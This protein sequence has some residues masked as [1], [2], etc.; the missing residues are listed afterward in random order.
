ME[1]PMDSR[2][3]AVVG[4]QAATVAGIVAYRALAGDQPFLWFSIVLFG[5]A[6]IL[7]ESLSERREGGGFTTY[8]IVA[9]MGGLVATNGLSI[10]LAALFGAV[11][12]RGQNRRDPW[13][14]IFNGLQYAVSIGLASLVYSGLG[15]LSRSLTLGQA[16]RSIPE[17]LL[18]ALVFYVVNSLQVALAQGFEKSLPLRSFYTPA[19]LLLAV[20]QLLY[21]LVGMVAGIIYAQNAF[22]V[23]ERLVAG[24]AGEVLERIVTGSSGEAIRGFAGLAAFFTLLAVAWYFSGK[25][26]A[27]RRG[28]DQALMTLAGYLERREPY[29]PGHSERVAALA[30]MTAK[31]LKVGSYDAARLFHAALLHDIGKAAVPRDILLKQGPFDEEE[32][33]RVKRH[34]LESGQ[35][36][37]SIDYLEEEAQVVYHHHEEFDGGGYIDGL[38][39]E[40]IPLGARIL[41]VADA[42]DAMT[43]DRP[44]RPAK[45]SQEA[46][47]ELRQNEGVKFDH[48]VVAA[49]LAG[50]EELQAAEERAAVEQMEEEGEQPPLAAVGR[51]W[52]RAEAAERQRRQSKTERRRLEL[53]ERRKLRERVEHE[54]LSGEIPVVRPE[55]PPESG[56]PWQEPVPAREE[57]EDAG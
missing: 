40:T 17:L 7:C 55:E 10:T 57:D 24:P 31:K 46:I 28:Y 37:E 43:S 45:T 16:F 18:A 11:S 50:L 21:S 41:A 38:A 8:G 33:E 47:A 44:W 5:L 42:Y 39:G 13:R 2:L 36:L 27:L 35:R 32:F 52:K 53:Q 14:G 26:I 48:Q 12:L 20:N 51:L 4:V 23:E 49:F 6:M 30:A 19:T 15:G 22:H 9:L 56:A 34:P 1:V 29:L 25:D 3:K 54:S